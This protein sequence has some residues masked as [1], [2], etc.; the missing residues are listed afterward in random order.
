MVADLP[1]VFASEVD[2]DYAAGAVLFPG[3][4]LVGWHDLIGRDLEVFVG[5]GGKLGEIVFGLV[6][7]IFAAEPRHGDDVHYAGDGAD[8][9]AVIDG[10]E[11]G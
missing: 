3:G 4:K 8:L 9:V 1:V 2:I 11:V 10:N 7:F 6:V 5:V